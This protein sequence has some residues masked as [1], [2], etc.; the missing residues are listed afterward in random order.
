MTYDNWKQQTPPQFLEE[1][2]DAFIDCEICK[3]AISV[4]ELTTVFFRGR[5]IQ[6]CGFCKEEVEQENIK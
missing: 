1:M 6:C 4:D 2:E 3:E 5:E